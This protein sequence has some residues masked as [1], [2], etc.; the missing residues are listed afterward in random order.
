MITLESTVIFDFTR[1][2]TMSKIPITSW[3]RKSP[4]STLSSAVAMINSAERRSFYP[5]A[6][7]RRRKWF[8][9]VI[10]KQS[11]NST[12]VCSS[13]NFILANLL[14][15]S[16]LLNVRYCLRT[17]DQY[18]DMDYVVIYFHHGLRSF[19]RPSYGWLMKA[20]MK[21]DRKWESTDF[22]RRTSQSQFSSIDTR[23]M[24]K[25]FTLF[26]QPNG[27]NFCGP[28]FVHSSGKNDD[29][30]VVR[31]AWLI[32]SIFQ[33]EIL[34]KGDLHQS[35]IGT[36]WIRAFIEHS[37][38]C[39][40]ERVGRKTSVDVGRARSSSFRVD[41]TISLQLAAGQIRPTTKFHVSLDLFVEMFSSSLTRHVRRKKT[42]LLV[43]WKMNREKRFRQ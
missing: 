23:K 29:S 4:I 31:F 24:S 8:G 1:I 42:F 10:S 22:N 37:N 30:I 34:T 32:W 14:K 6:V 26:I 35:S 5:P 36:K 17:F 41:P 13:K 3:W 25:L 39:G 43:F 12:N 33:F 15:F 27:S 28:Y 20:Y 16:P 2:C 11:I 38:P 21:V 9:T 40:S 19:N 7:Y 18:A